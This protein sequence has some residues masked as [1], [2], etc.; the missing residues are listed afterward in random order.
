M[1]GQQP[2]PQ[3]GLLV[4]YSALMLALLLAALDQTIV[5]T[6]LLTK[7]SRALLGADADRNLIDSAGQ[8]KQ[9]GSQGRH[10]RAMP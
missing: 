6:A 4:I 3:R 2:T 7:L 9:R 5:A 1:T 10:R 8:E